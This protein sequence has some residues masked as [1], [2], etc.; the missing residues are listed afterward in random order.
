MV[1]RVGGD[2]MKY[3][4]FCCGYNCKAYVHAAV[5]SIKAQTKKDF[6]A[7]GVDDC[8]TDTTFFQL[9]G[10]KDERFAIIKN[11]TRRGGT[12]T[13]LRA[14]QELDGLGVDVMVMLDMDDQLLPGALE[15][16]AHEYDAGA[17]MTY[18]NWIDE[19]GCTW[20]HRPMTPEV[21]EAMWTSS[22][23]W[24]LTHAMTF[25]ADL[26]RR[27]PNANWFHE[28][29]SPFGSGQSDALLMLA[30]AGMAGPERIH[31][32]PDTIYRYTRFGGESCLRIVPKPER[33]GDWAEIISRPRLAR[34]EAL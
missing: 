30:L 20:P 27:I 3:G 32:I 23:N 11:D 28:D 6:V 34:V 8:S 1:G 19:R 15:R 21:Y 22:A 33:D 26:W 2:A 10:A 16:I 9:N 29:R 14:C 17:W 24:M 4:I 12:L 18:G 25:R 31:G 13:R 5:E 7:V